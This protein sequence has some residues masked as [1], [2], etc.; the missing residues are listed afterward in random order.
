MCHK[1]CTAHLSQQ[2]IPQLGK[3]LD[4]ACTHF[5]PA[6][7]DEDDDD[8][9]EEDDDTEDEDDAEDDDGRILRVMAS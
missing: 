2:C 4:P 8:D 6:W 5:G 1:D 7:K 9:A 3:L